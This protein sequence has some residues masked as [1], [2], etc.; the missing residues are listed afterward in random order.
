ML[1]N[2]LI[3]YRT[4]PIVQTQSEQLSWS[5]LVELMYIENNDER[6]FYEQQSIQN[7]LSVRQLQ[8]QTLL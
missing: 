4:Y 6:K 8:K 7:M 3:F 2:S 5:H 1:G